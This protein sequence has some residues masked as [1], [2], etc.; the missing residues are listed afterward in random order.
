MV[1]NRVSFL[2]TV[3]NNVSFLLIVC[4]SLSS[5]LLPIGL[6][7]PAL[8]V[9]YSLFSHRWLFPVL[10][11]LGYSLLL[12]I[13]LFPPAHPGLFPPSLPRWYSRF[14]VGCCSPVPQ[15]CAYCSVLFPPPTQGRLIPH[16]VDNVEYPSPT[17]G[18]EL[19]IRNVRMLETHG[20]A[21]REETFLHIQNKPRPYR[22]QAENDQETR[23][24]EYMRTRMSGI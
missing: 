17:N 9:G 15:R 14:T 8:T 5:F 13:G 19:I 11:P 16:N 10:S 23:H 2:L 6:C 3:C 7:P 20:W 21:G 18:W 4:N 24:R 12:P 1:C 22:K